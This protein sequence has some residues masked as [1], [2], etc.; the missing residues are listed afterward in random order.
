RASSLPAASVLTASPL[1]SAA[2]FEVTVAVAEHAERAR[3][4]DT[5][6][7][8]FVFTAFVPLT[9]TRQL[10]SHVGPADRDSGVNPLPRDVASPQIES[11][12]KVPLG[13]VAVVYGKIG[14]C[15]SVSG[16]W[17]PLHDPSDSV[18]LDLAPAL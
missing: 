16:P 17:Q 2:A 1:A 3:A 13:C 18:P 6:A 14:H 15:E 10:A 9:L 4:I 8:S 7:V 5:S 12:L 11:A